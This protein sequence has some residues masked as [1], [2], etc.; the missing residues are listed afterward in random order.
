MPFT[1]LGIYQDSPRLVII[2]SRGDR[3][4]TVSE[5]DVIDGTYRVD[6]VTDS[7]VELMYLPLKIKQTL[8]MAAAS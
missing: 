4:Y 5:G 7:A 3:V 1:F 6:Q 8:S 2:L